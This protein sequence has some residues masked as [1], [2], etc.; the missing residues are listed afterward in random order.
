MS[1]VA[2]RKSISTDKTIGQTEK[3][4][5]GESP[6]FF[7]CED[8]SSGALVP[9]GGADG[10]VPIPKTDTTAAACGDSSSGLELAVPLSKECE[11][12]KHKFDDEARAIAKLKSLN[13]PWVT[14][15]DELLSL[16]HR[17]AAWKTDFKGRLKDAKS[18]VQKPGYDAEKIR[19]KW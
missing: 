5:D 10:R 1:L 17:F 18:K 8:S 15:G 16:K 13:I 2:A 9:A 14:G 11:Q 7:D 19:R 3:I 6:R 4:P 12:K